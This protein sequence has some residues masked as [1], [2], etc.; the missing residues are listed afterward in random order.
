M[1]NALLESAGHCLASGKLC[2]HAERAARA[3]LPAAWHAEQGPSL[4]TQQSH[5]CVAISSEPVASLAAPPAVPSGAGEGPL[6][7]RGQGSIFVAGEGAAAME[8]VPQL[9]LEVPATVMP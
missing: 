5:Q 6:V 7:L 9:L 2:K 4:Q 3:V 1:A 8:R